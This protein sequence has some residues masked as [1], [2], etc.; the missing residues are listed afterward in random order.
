MHSTKPSSDGKCLRDSRSLDPVTP[1]ARVLAEAFADDPLMTFFWPDPD[2]RRRALPYFWHSRVESR[3]RKGIVDTASDDTGIVSVV[4]WDLPGTPTPIA[5]PL[6]MIRALGGA[7]P[8]ALATSRKIEG[9]RPKH[10]HLY[11][12]CGGTLPHAPRERG[13]RAA[14]ASASRG[15]P[16]RHLRHRHK[17]L[18]RNPCRTRRLPPHRRTGCRPERGPAR[19]AAPRVSTANSCTTGIAAGQGVL[20][21]V[22]TSSRGLC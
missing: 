17:R 4:L 6:S 7:T 11:L 8:R 5:K 13:D 14:G 19:N 18:Q 20:P 1:E 10:P 9:L 15:Q 3:R 16:S 2:R 12:A 21:G 22:F